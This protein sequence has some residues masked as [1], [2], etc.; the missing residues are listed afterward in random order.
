M[1]FRFA[2][3]LVL[4]A[5]ATRLLPHPHNFTPIGAI[6]L[7]GA[8]YF[9]Q[10]HWAILIPFLSLFLSDLFLN[11][12]VYREYYDGFQFIT[13]PWIYVA[14]FLT[15]ALGWLMLRHRSIRPERVAL[16]ALG[17]SFLFF[18]ITNFEVWATSTMYPHTSGG[19]LACYVAGLPFLKNAIFGDLFFSAVLFGVYEFMYRRSADPTMAEKK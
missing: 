11:N 4:M 19:L 3:L 5:A 1:K 9:T 16:T 15:T 6:G 8:A 10:R 2:V 14:F 12:V 7:F 18:G 13:S 17:A